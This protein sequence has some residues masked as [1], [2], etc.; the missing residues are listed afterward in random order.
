MN[1]KRELNPIY[2]HKD[3]EKKWQSYWEKNKTFQTNL[4]DF[5]KD[6]KYVLPMFPYPSGSG[7]HVGHVR[8]YTITD[9]MARFYRMMGYNVLLVTGWDAFGLPSEQY[10]IQ[11]NNHPS[12]FTYQNIQIF[13]NQL[14]KLGFSYDWSKEINTS[15]PDYYHWTQW[16]FKKIYLEGL[17][18]YKDIPVYWCE[19]LATVLSNEEIKT[20]DGKKF[21]ER[22]SFPVVK[23]NIPQWILKIT[24]YSHQLSSGL[25]Q[26]DWPSSIKNLQKNWIGISAGANIK[27]KVF[28]KE[29]F[30]I[31]VFT[32][33][34]D[35]IYGVNSIS[36]SYSHKLIDKLVSEEF[37]D[38]VNNFCKFLE[39]NDSGISKISEEILGEF[40]GSYCIN[41]INNE[42]IPIWVTNFAIAD[43][44]TGSLMTSP[45]N[46][47]VLNNCKDDI[48]LNKK[49]IEQNRQIDYRF[50]E[51]FNLP[52]R[53]FVDFNDNNDI[54]YVNSPF[55][56]GVANRKIAIEKIIFELEK[57]ELGK[58]TFS[59]HLKDWVFSRQ[60]YWG[61]PIPIVHFENG[62][63]KL[64]SDED[65]PLTLPQLNDFKPSSQY[66]SPLQKV[67][68]WINVKK[69]N[70][71]GIRDFN[72]M[73]Q[74]A[75]SCWYYIAFLLR[76][77]SEDGSFKY[78][79]LD[80]ERMKK[81][82]NH[83]LPVDLYVG[84]QEHANLHLLYS[85]FWH[86]VLNKT[87][88][89][90]SDEPFQKLVCQGMIL[91]ESGEK[92]SKSKGN[93]INPDD[94]VE[95]W[96]SDSLRLYEIFLGP[97]DQSANF[98]IN[99]VASMRKWLNRVYALFTKFNYKFTSDLKSN[100]DLDIL[101]QNTV[102]EV[103]NNYNDLKLN[104][105]VARLME[106]INKCYSSSRI[107]L[108]Y[109]KEFLKLLNPIA[110]HITEE[111]WSSFEDYSISFS[112]WPVINNEF[113]YKS[114]FTIVV[115]VDGKKKCLLEFDHSFDKEEKILE[116]A[117]NNNK[118]FDYLISRE[119]VKTIFI[120]NK[121]INFVTKEKII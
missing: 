7:L 115:Q 53:K 70:E 79:S 108:L 84:G 27:F 81:I 98:D 6:K 117:K 78:N 57:I 90:K 25:D 45:F 77:F 2:S 16:I 55:I 21:S 19:G 31:E 75:G 107:P 85:R 29:E 38:R 111:I 40:I 36:L 32:T 83:W 88:V 105:I 103:T 52:I 46:K 64:V 28:N 43:Y 12:I 22:G 66:Y 5:K 110:P 26:L 106:F 112:N 50:S 87:G 8:N 30:F 96:G 73:P 69:G 91:G 15:E 89:V 95:N 3:V 102:L 34:A 47:E 51:K 100:D 119:I 114:K 93:V 18:E 9:A 71:I 61:E 48:F 4:E 37:R 10:A 20:I 62:E 99:G 42:L 72:V 76:K 65:L 74:W 56:N 109:G 39:E 94:C 68:E 35:T 82:I 44:G 54:I 104:L 113:Q 58:K 60:R 33:R 17:A 24:E 80:D 14:I 118:V 101:F 11:T 67:P 1:A 97:V 49:E 116:V 92:M 63:D 23:R 120:K 13:K 59:Y 121:L 41:P 86:K